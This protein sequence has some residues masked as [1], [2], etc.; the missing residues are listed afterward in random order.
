MFSLN[1]LDSGWLNRYIFYRLELP[2]SPI[3]PYLEIQE[4]DLITEKFDDN[5]YSVVKENGILFGCPVISSSTIKLAKKLK[6]PKKR[7][8]TILLFLETLFSVALT[9]NESLIKKY[10]YRVHM[11]Y[12]IR[13]LKIILLILKYFLPWSYFRIPPN[14]SLAELL[15][16]NV[17]MKRA[18][19][20]L[21][22]VF[23][24]S[25]TI[26]GYSSLG[27]RQNNFA[28]SK[29]Y[30]FLLWARENAENISTKPDFYHKKDAQLREEMISIFI[31][32]IWTDNFVEKSEKNVIKKYIVQ[33]GL[34]K[35]KKDILFM[36]IRQPIKIVDIQFS[37]TSLIIINYLIQQLILLSLVDNQK[38]WQEKKLIEN[39]SQH[40]GI[41]EIELEPLYCSVAEF[42]SIHNKKIEF[43]R[44]NDRAKQF[45]DFIN[46][47]VL[48]LV[49]KNLD[50][51]IKEIKE[52]KELS[53]LLFKATSSPLSKEEKQKVQMQLIDIARSIPALAIFALP[54]GGLLLPVLIKL[55]PFNILPSAFQ[56]NRN[57]T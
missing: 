40:L 28:F 24:E 13:F 34:P 48:S 25:V 32:L 37:F 12:E 14:F 50:N 49:R 19:E 18:L 15:K 1:L 30:F 51:I 33:T 20:R 21:E 57:S 23:L 6:F 4:R 7:G 3:N 9:E 42:L 53:E 16:K 46:N 47:I 11:S 56:D 10:K 39:I 45:Q 17:P 52:T 2:F 44:N 22:V 35:S 27:N 26:K 41:S 43:L 5:L 8:T 54:G 36:Q 31:T 38:A 29:L 55:L